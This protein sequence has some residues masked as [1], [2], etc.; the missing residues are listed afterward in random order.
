MDRI[1]WRWVL[2]AIQVVLTIAAF[3]YAP[4]EYKAAP[5]PIGDCIGNLR[6]QV[7]PPPG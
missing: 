6:A 4:Y 2:P 3:V 5:H 1:S 7:W